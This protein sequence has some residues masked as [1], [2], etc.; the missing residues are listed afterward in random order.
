MTRYLKVVAIIMI[1]IVMGLIVSGCEKKNEIIERIDKLQEGNSF[2]QLAVGEEQYLY[3]MYNGNGEAM[4]E[5]YNGG[6]GFYRKDDK[7]V[8]V[9]EN[10]VYI[11][12]DINP[13]K[14]I[15]YAVEVAESSENCSITKEED[16]NQEG[17]AVHTIVINGKDNIKKLYD[18]AND[19]EYSESCIEVIYSAMENIKESSVIIK[20]YTM[21]SG[22]F[23]ASCDIALKSD[24]EE[25]TYTNWIFDGYVETVDWELDDEWYSNDTSN[26]EHWRNLLENKVYELSDKLDKVFTP[27]STET[28]SGAVENTAEVVEDTAG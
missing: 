12:T 16:D 2:I 13:L 1:S 28:E 27:N 22:E 7:L 25:Q 24:S 8:T 4:V 10:E 18:K 26:I 6:I 15:K 5:S 11:E 9:G 3:M 20:V 21:E 19:N 17:K 23:G 14:F